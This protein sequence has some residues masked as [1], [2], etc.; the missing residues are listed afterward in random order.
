MGPQLQVLKEVLPLD[1][2]RNRWDSKFNPSKNDAFFYRASSRTGERVT[3]PGAKGGKA[4]ASSN[5]LVLESFCKDSFTLTH[6]PVYCINI[7]CLYIPMAPMYGIFPFI[8]LIFYGRRRWKWNGMHGSYGI[9]TIVGL[10]FRH[11]G[12]FKCFKYFTKLKDSLFL[13][14]LLKDDLL[15]GYNSWS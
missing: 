4:G 13:N 6:L 3:C 10:V 8:W 14:F 9:H 15:R 2:F 12:T 11:P 1:F 5:L 7:S